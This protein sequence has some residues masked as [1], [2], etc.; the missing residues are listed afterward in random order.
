MCRDFPNVLELRPFGVYGPGEHFNRFPSYC[1]RKLERNE[2]IV[3]NQERM[4]SYIY[5][6]DLAKLIGFFVN[7][8]PL[9]RVIDI[10]DPQPISIKSIAKL[11]LAI[12]EARYTQT[13]EIAGTGPNY[14]ADTSALKRIDPPIDFTTYISGLIELY[15]YN[16]RSK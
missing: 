15:N 1:F 6:K 8:F 7:A 5:V 11:C 2:P 13:I 16:R 3:I 9:E 4:M 10:A 14:L 12:T